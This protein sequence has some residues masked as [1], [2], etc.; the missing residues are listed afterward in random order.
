MKKDLRRGFLLKTSFVIGSALA[1]LPW[2]ASAQQ[3]KFNLA[4]MTS[5]AEFQN[6]NMVAWGED[7]KKGTNGAVQITMHGSGSL[8]KNPEIKRAV[9]TGQIE[10][11]TQLMQ[12]LG[13]EKRLFEIDG[14]P[15][16]AAGYDQGMKLWEISRPYAASY[17]NK[18][19]LRLLYAVPWPGQGFFLK[20]EMNSLADAKG[21]RQ[22]AYNEMTSRLAQLMGTVPTTVQITELPQA[23]ITG[24]VQMFNTSSP[25][26]AAYK[27][28]EFSSHFYD[29]NAWLP[30]HMLFANEQ[31]FSNL[32]ANLQKVI[33]NA[34]AAAEKRGWEMSRQQTDEARKKLS[35]AGTKVVKPSATLQRELDKIGETMRNEWMQKADDDAKAVMTQYLKAMGK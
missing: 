27:V 6:V 16:L 8:Y 31:V 15:F 26:A 30:K 11:G 18:Q 20:K 9:Q 4:D 32:P 1:G 5:P 33:I 22:R 7:I 35:D 34:S 14:I 10:F 23:M 24:T 12:N 19:G 17:M 2:G 29:T 28:W 13:P 25:S 3:F 21:L